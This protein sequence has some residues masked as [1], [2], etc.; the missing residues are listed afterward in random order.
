MKG[1]Q[2]KKIELVSAPSIFKTKEIFKGSRY[3]SWGLNRRRIMLRMQ[4]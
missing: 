3:D 2:K 1:I 4:Q